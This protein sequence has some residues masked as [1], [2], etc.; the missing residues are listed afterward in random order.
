MFDIFMIM[1]SKRLWLFIFATLL[2][3]SCRQKHV[4]NANVMT[5]NVDLKAQ[6]PIK[7]I[8]T[9]VEFVR[10]ED[11]GDVLIGSVWE[12]FITE[13]HIIVVDKLDSKSIFIFNR[14]GKFEALIDKIGKGP[15]EY[16]SISAVA[17][18]P[19]EQKIAVLDNSGQK[20]LYYD[21]GGQYVSN[22]PID[23]YKNNFEYVSDNELVWC[24]YGADK[25]NQ[26][27][28]PENLITF[29]NEH[30]KITGGA[31]P[32]RFTDPNFNNITPNLRK[33]NDKVYVN[34]SLSDT[35]Y[36]VDGTKLI[37]EYRM[38][39]TPVNGY[40]NPEP[41]ITNEEIRDLYATKSFFSGDYYVS[42]NRILFS[43]SIPPGR[44]VKYLLYSNNKTY[45]LPFDMDN[46]VVSTMVYHTKTVY[47]EKFVSIIP[48]VRLLMGVPDNATNHS[49][50]KGLTE[51]CNPVVCF[52]A[53]KELDK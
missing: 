44:M 23:F 53:I 27:M 15:Q 38:D 34:P 43:I 17:L 51:D 48:A 26:G 7:D 20:V 1:R 52:Y 10:L 19:D 3:C 5:V 29:T 25:Q 31:L 13:N 18:T 4:D 6:I 11:T 49:V 32:D 46:F 21:M 35:I 9:D 22:Q 45:N 30:F 40:V 28:L 16:V 47:K 12:L 39:M 41:D 33:F 50:Y 14:Q 24:S 42:G 8:V 2:L 36:R 37:G